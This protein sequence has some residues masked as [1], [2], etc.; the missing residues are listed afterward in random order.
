MNEIVTATYVRVFGRIN[1]TQLIAVAAASLAGGFLYQ[2][3]HRLPFVCAGAAFG[4]AA[5]VALRL[6]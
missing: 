3:D 4:V 5:L 1:G 2:V 6:A